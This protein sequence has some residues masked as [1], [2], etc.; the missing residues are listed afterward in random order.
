MILLK[1]IP[2]MG[3]NIPS[4]IPKP[5]ANRRATNRRPSPVGR[6][7]WEKPI[8]F[9]TRDIHT[10]LRRF[11]DPSE[12]KVARWLYSTW[13][14]EKKALKFQEIQNAMQ[15]GELSPDWLKQWKQDYSLFINDVLDPQWRA[16]IGDG[17]DLMAARLSDA[18]G[19]PWQFP[20][21]T[22]RIENWINN[23][24]GALIVDLSNE[25]SKAVRNILRRSIADE[26]LST[27]E[28]G[29]RLRSSIGLTNV[30]ANAVENRRQKLL[31]LVEKGKLKADRVDGLCNKYSDFLLRRR[32][33]RIARTETATAFNYG[34]FEGIRE[35]RDEGLLQGTV[36]K[37]FS[38]AA[39][40]R[41]CPFCGPLDG[42]I[43]GLEETFP[44]LT[45]E[46]PNTFTPPVH[47][48]CRCTVEYGVTDLQGNVSVPFPIGIDRVTDF[49]RDRLRNE[50]T[51]LVDTATLADRTSNASQMRDALNANALN[52]KTF[53]TTDKR[54]QISGAVAWETNV[55]RDGVLTSLGSLGSGSKAG[56][57]MVNQ[58]MRDVSGHGIGA[59]IQMTDDSKSFFTRQLRLPNPGKD[60][61]LLIMN[62]REVA[63]WIERRG[64]RRSGP[65][66]ERP[67]ARISSR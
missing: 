19:V 65:T 15:S 61:N 23:R 6:F 7:P 55:G 63:N 52:S 16:G 34:A 12:K 5:T 25:Q 11:T 18:V 40:E 9:N 45:G 56:T 53:Y 67:V 30:D 50:L 38:T 41:V 48:N 24:G 31:Q 51:D 59:K 54:G 64:V 14:A 29:I 47:P 27:R 21:T 3:A 13:N 2:D 10:E 26:G 57:E 60:N 42:Q 32:A 33:A 17:A 43:I 20:D 28:L 1:A 36:V 22:R 37:R 49:N 4:P 58:F 35:A 8:Y 46:L 66:F 39:D 62:N 44:G